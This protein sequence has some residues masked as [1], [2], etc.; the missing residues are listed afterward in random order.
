M[1]LYNWKG[2]DG[3]VHIEKCTSSDMVCGEHST[4][5]KTRENPTC[6]KCLLEIKY[7]FFVAKYLAKGGYGS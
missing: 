5:I 4:C 3:V 1:V 6:E 7:A 2:S